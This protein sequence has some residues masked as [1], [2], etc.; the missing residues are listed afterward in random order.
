MVVV[1]IFEG[2]LLLK[3]LQLQLH[4][5]ILNALELELQTLLLAH[6]G[7]SSMLLKLLQAELI[8][9]VKK[10]VSVLEHRLDALILLKSLW[11]LVALPKDLMLRVEVV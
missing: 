2:L 8:Q 4:P 9:I 6:E 7:D 3:L 11:W 10:A 1:D 5:T